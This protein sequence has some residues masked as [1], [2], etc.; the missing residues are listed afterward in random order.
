MKDPLPDRIFNIFNSMFLLFCLAIFIYP[1]IFVLSA[2]FSSVD[3]MTSGRVWLWPVDITFDG[4]F[5]VFNYNNIWLGYTNSLFYA[6]VGTVISVVLTIMVGYA[7]SRKDLKG[8]LAITFLF[9][10]TMLFSGGLIPTYLVVRSL[11]MLDT[12]WAIL[13]PNAIGVWN[14]IITRTFFQT[15][16]PNELL[17]ASRLDGASDYRFVWSVVLPLSS[18]IIAVI[19]LFYAVGQWNSYFPALM[20]LRSEHLYPLQIFL[21]DALI[22]NQN[23]IA[24]LDIELQLKLA[25]ISELMRYSIIIVA[26]VPV[27]LLYPFVQKY[28]VKGL[29]IGAIKG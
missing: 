6:S 1:L 26:S 19:S 29:M 17:E 13:L 4:Y 3:A 5:A 2:S 10:F 23:L 9:T 16:I 27:L 25:D 15:T 22:Q 12:R 20:Y 21:R 24:S 8:R 14:I 18:P 7:L 28:F 11:G